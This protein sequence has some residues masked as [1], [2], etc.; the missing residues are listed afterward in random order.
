MPDELVSVI[1]DELLTAVQAAVAGI[2]DTATVP[3]PA[4]AATFANAGESANVGAAW[5]TVMS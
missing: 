4:V 2:A 5:F 3:A 1:Q